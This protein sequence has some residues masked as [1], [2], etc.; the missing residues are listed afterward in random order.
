MIIIKFYLGPSI[1]HCKVMQLNHMM[2]NHFWLVLCRICRY[3]GT[4]QQR[5]KS[6]SHPNFRCQL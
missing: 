6:L 1:L 2:Y 4:Y 3:C 5:G